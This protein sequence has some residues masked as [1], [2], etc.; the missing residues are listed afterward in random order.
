MDEDL[1]TIGKVLKPVGLQGEV[2]VALLTDFPERFDALKGVHVQTKHG[3]AFRLHIAGIRHGPPFVYLSFVDLTDISEV[4]ALRGALLQVPASERVSLPEGR[5]FQS[6]LLGL[7]VYTKEDI[8]L[9]KVSDIIETGSHDVFVVTGEQGEFLIP[10]QHK[11]VTEIDLA[12]KRM[13]VDPIEG[14]LDL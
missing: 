12:G 7:D 13:V 6:D 1:F 4:T 14:L 11:F 10:A 2:K 9:G 3:E 5:Y 8:V